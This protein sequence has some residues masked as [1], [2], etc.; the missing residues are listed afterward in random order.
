MNRQEIEKAIRVIN[1][2]KSE[3]N[4]PHIIAGCEFAISAL[5][6]QLTNGWIPCK[7]RQPEKSDIYLATFTEYGERYVERFYYSD[8][9][10]W[11]TP[12]AWQD[13]GRIDEIL[14]WQPLPKPWEGEEE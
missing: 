9:V 13:E 8:I 10:G 1:H 5:E 4:T 14:A 6:E 2:Y 7:E 3:S 11:M 12:V